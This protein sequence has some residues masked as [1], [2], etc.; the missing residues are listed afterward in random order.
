MTIENDKIYD[1]IDR[2]VCETGTAESAVIPILHAIQKKYNYLPEIALKRVCE[3]TGITPASI[4]GVS[5]FYTQFRHTPVGEHIIY[6]CNGTACHVKGSDLVYDAFFRELGI[7]DNHDTDPDGLFTIQKVACLGCCTLA[8]VV[9]IDDITYGDVK[10]N[11]AA[12]ILHDFLSCRRE[13]DTQQTSE[14]VGAIV[15]R[16]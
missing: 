3:T 5:T 11:N 13:K 10:I 2:I 1:D 9:Q 8:P 4:T 6:V 15:K 16:V 14:I 12:H 7:G